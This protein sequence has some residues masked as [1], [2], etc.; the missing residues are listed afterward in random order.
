MVVGIGILGEAELADPALAEA[1][2]EEV[3]DGD[4]VGLLVGERLAQALQLG[5]GA[6]L[7]LD[8]QRRP[9]R[10]EHAHGVTPVLLATPP[11]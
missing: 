10:S 1:A 11:R 5:H 9:E 7:A 3:A 8:I 6:G 4:P 2:P